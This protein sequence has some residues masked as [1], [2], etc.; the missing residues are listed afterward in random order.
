MNFIKQFWHKLFCKEDNNFILIREKIKL[1]PIM[2]PVV[3]TIPAFTNNFGSINQG[4]KDENKTCEVVW[5]VTNDGKQLTEFDHIENC[6]CDK[7]D[8]F[9][10]ETPGAL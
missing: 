3:L 5:A 7:A 2:M 9:L 1:K 10:N 4:R 6:S 8:K